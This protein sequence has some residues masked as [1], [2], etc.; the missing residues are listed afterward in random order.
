MRRLHKT[1]ILPSLMAAILAGPASAD[2]IPGTYTQTLDNPVLLESWYGYS[3][4]YSYMHANPAE[5]LGPL[6]PGEYAQATRDGLVTHASLSMTFHEID[7]IVGDTEAVKVWAAPAGSGNNYSLLGTV[8]SNGTTTF[9]LIQA[10]GAGGG[11]DG[12]PVQVKLI[13]GTGIVDLAMLTQSVL[14]V[15]IGAGVA[16]VP[17]PAAALLCAIGLGV[18][19]LARRRAG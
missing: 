19:G 7:S 12:L 17:A 13:G 4:P 9:D 10:F 18:A 16:P 6:T 5:S 11:L 2:V 8:T 3:N 15:S 14:R 1:L